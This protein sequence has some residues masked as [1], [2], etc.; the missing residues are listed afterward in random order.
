VHENWGLGLESRAREVCAYIPLGLCGGVEGAILASKPGQRM[1][2]A[3]EDPVLLAI[4]RAELWRDS[5][6]HAR[7]GCV[8]RRRLENSAGDDAI[9]G[10]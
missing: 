10:C 5:R 1:P 2:R 4:M 8:D 3:S 9:S 6:C 7:R